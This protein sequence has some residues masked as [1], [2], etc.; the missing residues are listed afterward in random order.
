MQE[1]RKH[2]HYFS[3]KH[4]VEII[5]ISYLARPLFKSETSPRTNGNNF[6][7]SQHRKHLET[8]LESSSSTV[9]QWEDH[10]T[11]RCWCRSCAGSFSVT[12]RVVCSVG[13]TGAGTIVWT[14]EIVLHKILHSNTWYWR[15]WWFFMDLNVFSNNANN[16]RV[17]WNNLKG[18]NNY[19][20]KM[21]HESQQKHKS[22]E[23][24]MMPGPLTKYETS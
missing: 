7:A 8:G 11:G 18:R 15:V 24:F 13:L 3:S 14:W 20:N 23:T 10:R 1:E 12:V 17:S 5:T 21:K 9:H 16:E 4:P 22:C 19:N 6:K 2:K